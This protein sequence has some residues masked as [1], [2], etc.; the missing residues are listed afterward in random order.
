MTERSERADL[1]AIRV[2]TGQGPGG[3][4]Y[5]PGH[6]GEVTVDDVASLLEEAFAAGWDER[7]RVKDWELG[8]A[9][10]RLDELKREQRR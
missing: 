5:D 2:L 4:A 1:Y 6:A 3:A 10:R 9:F 8:D 7:G